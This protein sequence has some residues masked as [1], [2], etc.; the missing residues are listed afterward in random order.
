ML[1]LVPSE[2]LE[3]P[4]VLRALLRGD[5][6]AVDAPGD[7]L[8]GQLRKGREL[9]AAGIDRVQVRTCQGRVVLALSTYLRT[10]A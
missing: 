3:G 2:P 5:H 10:D 8:H 6:F 4:Q 9:V 1:T 7:F